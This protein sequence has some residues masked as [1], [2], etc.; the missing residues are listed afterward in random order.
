MDEQ[1]RKN[2]DKLV[3]KCDRCGACVRVCP[4]YEVDP[5]DRAASRGK[6]A[7]TRAYLEGKLDG[8][9][10]A[11]RH[12]LDYCLLCK[13]C[14]EVCPNKIMTDEAMIQMRESLGQEHGLSP[15]YRLIGGFMGSNG[16]KKLAAPAV[17]VAQRAKLPKLT[18]Y[19]LPKNAEDLP[20]DHKGPALFAG[21]ARPCDI[22][23]SKVHR[24][25]YFRGC[26]MKLFFK[27]A[28]AASVELLKKTGRT[29][30]VPDVNCCGVP[31]QS[32]G[33]L[34]EARELA[35]HNIELLA[36][37]D[38]IVTDCG[39]CASTLKE[40]GTRYKDDFTMSA[41]AVQV[42]AK[43]MSLTQ[44][45]Y[46]VGYHPT[47]HKDLRVTYH[48]SCHLNRGL[49]VM[50]EPEALLEEAVTYLP[51]QHKDMCCGGA[52]T[53]QVDF[54]DISKKVL[55]KKYEDFEATGADIVVAECPSCLMQLGKMEAMGD[56]KLRVLHI[57]QVL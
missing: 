10:K 40:Y 11:L 43:V 12:A 42:S 6:I 2:L 9:D 45:L 52:G 22:D 4:L 24:I 31:Q 50:K 25:A 56:K 41:K 19:L 49:G 30:E 54:P 47:P 48:A 57:S 36:D 29:V 53:F 34:D 23:L 46:A 38:L 44:Y 21:D 8:G 55:R 39:S 51:A 3:R 28:S 14:T 17:D 37:Y 15:K 32:H 7:I 13:A 16:L 26:A 33:L 18:R 20:L 1:T 35:R 5:R 27:N